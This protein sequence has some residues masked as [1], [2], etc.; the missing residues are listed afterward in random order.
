MPEGD[1]I[2]RAARTLHRALA[3]QTITRFVSEL[4]P[5]A[6]LNR[7]EPMAG[8]LVERVEAIGKHCLMHVSGRPDVLKAG[9]LADAAVVLSPSRRPAPRSG[10]KLI[11]STGE[12]EPPR[13]SGADSLVLRTHMRMNGS[14]HLYRPGERW[15]RPARAMRI[16][17]ETAE[18]VAVAFDVYAAEFIRAESLDRHRAI[19]TLGPDL[20]GAVDRD[21]LW[22]RIAGQGAR[23]VH[24]VLL[25]QR[26]MAGLGNVYKSELLFLA[27][28]HPDTPATAIDRETWSRLITD[29]QALLRDNV[30]EHAR[31]R[32]TTRRMDPSA[33][34]WV[35]GRGGRPCR[36]C[37]TPIAGRK[38]GDAARVTY[39]CPTCQKDTT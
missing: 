31:G 6:E 4:A 20:L 9:D 36:R 12:A 3:G 37:G 34:L 14:W 15:Q 10:A 13:S 30:A 32:R 33:G 25:D 17:I 38:N 8:R 39:W 16:A 19:A 18:W 24:D 26:V 23:P 21:D 1:T 27:G 22:A 35:Y 5:L 2:F 29:A 11:L 7:R 28:V